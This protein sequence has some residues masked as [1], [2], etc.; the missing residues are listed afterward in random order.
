MHAQD[1]LAVVPVLAP[2]VRC[3]KEPGGPLY[4]L[5]EQ[6]RFVVDE[7]LYAQLLAE[8]DGRRTAGDL[9]AALGGEHD[10][11]A[12]SF[13]L[14][15]L[16]ARGY[17][18]DGTR[19]ASHE[20]SSAWW[21]AAI[22]RAQPATERPTVR[23][24]Q[25]ADTALPGLPERLARMGFTLSERAQLAVVV[26]DDYLDPRLERI[27]AAHAAHAPAPRL[28]VPLKAS[29]HTLWLGPALFA[30]PEDPCWVCL[31]HRLERN[32][33]VE[34]YLQQ[35]AADA[36][37]PLPAATAVSLP[38]SLELAATFAAFALAHAALDPTQLEALRRHVLTLELPR[39]ERTWHR[40][41]KRPQCPG[42]GDPRALRTQLAA[43]VTLERRL[44]LRGTSGGHRVATPEQTLASCEPLISPITGVIARAGVVP[45]KSHPLR[46]VYG[47]SYFVSPAP[48]EVRDRR[49]AFSRPALG[50]GRTVAQARASAIA[51]ALERYAAHWSGDELTLR[52]S[53]RDL[54][55]RAL[56][57]DRLLHF[58]ARQYDA[59]LA[60]GGDDPRH[61]APLAYDPA[62][63]IAWTPAWS[64]RDHERRYLPASFVWNHMPV[65]ADERVC[66]FDPNG[67]AAGGC[68]EEAILQ[69][70]FELVERDAVALWW[71]NRLPCRGL[72]LESF[73]DTYLTDVRA[74]YAAL[75]WQLWALELPHDLMIPVVA[76]I[77]F[78]EHSGRFIV[79]FGCHLDPRLALERAVTE[80]HQVFDPDP[81]QRAPWTLADLDGHRFVWPDP[82]Q[83]LRTRAELRHETFDDLSQEVRSCVSRLAARG[84]DTIVLD[85]TRPDLLLHTVRVVVPGL[86]HFWRRLGPGR[87]Y[88]VPVE[89][90]LRPEPLAEHA[91]NPLALEL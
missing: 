29:G 58:S 87:L 22:D 84:L 14:S 67:C 27:V 3:V 48:G 76:A 32:R 44:R 7:A 68:R 86:R 49:S 19:G 13:A 75:G 74:H 30:E 91:L 15:D 28:L 25:A 50:K 17:V 71:Y 89:L 59:R 33:P 78:H 24:I 47:S 73:D 51:E 60:D 9:L 38:D 16:L 11:D 82:Q 90:G 72:S 77:A 8:V 63:T 66:A 21:G 53:A 41:G 4:V 2:G 45:G 26:V 65:A 42:C 46:L 23:V 62:R 40:V 69:G 1:P 79:G 83:P 34:R 52:A 54:G 12:V 88:D 81:A 56:A 55:Q 39:F 61:T 31:R 5:R 70:L 80:A 35:R 37:T 64:L 10:P 85:Y 43:P 20:A 57:P 6:Q 18:V 36:R